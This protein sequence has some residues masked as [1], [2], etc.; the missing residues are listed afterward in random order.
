MQK[1]F[2]KVWYTEQVVTDNGPQLD[3]NEFQ[4]FAQEYQFRHITSSPYYPRGNGEAE[5]GKKTVK[6]LLKKAASRIWRS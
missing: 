1:H 6:E 3:S 2:C 4:K 5:R